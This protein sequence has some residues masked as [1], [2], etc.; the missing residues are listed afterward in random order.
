MCQCLL[1][2]LAI[3]LGASGCAEI[4]GENNNRSKSLLSFKNETDGTITVTYELA[5]EQIDETFPPEPV[6]I[7]PG[8]QGSFA[9]IP[10]EDRCTVAPVV[11]VDEAGRELLRLPS[12]YCYGEDQSNFD[13]EGE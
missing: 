3:V 13:I 11:A 8:A 5:A 6:R 12:G 10:S 4:F 9:P 2:A 7:S 1:L